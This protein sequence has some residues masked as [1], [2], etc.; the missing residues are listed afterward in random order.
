MVVQ[1]SLIGL[2]D[3][4]YGWQ[5]LSDYAMR[6]S[7]NKPRNIAYFHFRLLVRCILKKYKSTYHSLKSRKAPHVAKRTKQPSWSSSSYQQ[8]KHDMTYYI[9][10]W[11]G[12]KTAAA[13]FS[14][15]ASLARFV[16]D[17]LVSVRYI[18]FYCSTQ[19]K[20]VNSS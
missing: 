15:F 18:F 2:L 10:Y 8:I 6:W 14:L 16:E 3:V 9:L 13:V 4:E 19:Q 11:T 12:Q 20:F 7:T 1:H 5:V 17:K